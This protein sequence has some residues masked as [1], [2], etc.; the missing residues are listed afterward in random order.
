MS[1][2]G[3][4][5]PVITLAEL[6]ACA[7]NEPIAGLNQASMTAVSIAYGNASAAAK[8]PCKEVFRMLAEIAGIHLTPAI[9]ARCGG[10][11]L[12]WRTGGP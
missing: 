9:G 12:R 3:D 2:E 7:L 6:E 5:P 1:S 4:E 11:V 8:S 10:L